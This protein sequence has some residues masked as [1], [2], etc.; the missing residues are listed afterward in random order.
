MSPYEANYETADFC[1]LTLNDT[2]LALIKTIGSHVPGGFLVYKASG[3]GQ[4]LYANPIVWE[5]F[6]CRSLPEFKALTGYTFR[7]MLHHDDYSVNARELEEQIA[8]NVGKPQHYVYRAVRK[9]GEIRWIDDDRHY[10]YTLEHGGVY[11]VFLSDITEARRKMEEDDAVRTTVIEA[12]LDAYTTILM[13]TDVETESLA[14]FKDTSA[15]HTEQVERALKLST[16]TPAINDYVDNMVAPEDRERVRAEVSLKNILDT[17]SRRK[18]FSVTYL[19]IYEG[20]DYYFRMQ[21]VRVP[22]PNGKT[23]IVI[24]FKNVDVSVRTQKHLEHQLQQSVEKQMQHEAEITKI[25]EEAL[26]DGLTGV[27]NKRC[28]SQTEERFNVSITDGSLTEFAVAVCDLNNLKTVN[29]KW[30]HIAGDTY[31]CEASRL[32][33]DTFKRSPVF[34]IGGDEFVAILTGED[35]ANRSSLADK[36][37][38]TVHEGKW[39]GGIVIACGVADYEP[40]HD[41]EIKTV[42]DR[43]DQRMY[44]VKQRLKKRDAAALNQP[45][46]PAAG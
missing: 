32:I 46:S 4:I 23:G 29:D 28:Y 8:Q 6:G 16:Y 45:A 39:P 43:A 33:C 37:S 35:Y 17:T 22:M 24:G 11:Y 21:F 40:G 10:A 27:K 36:L 41:V 12:L 3:D 42:F 38:N 34:R 14:V 30:G 31:I 20:R 1:S 7:G 19:Q 44:E 2:S 26:R 25:Q 13:V 15:T 9:D 18:H 5:I